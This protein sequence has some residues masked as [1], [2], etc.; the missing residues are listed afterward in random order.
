MKKKETFTKHNGIIAIW[1]FLFALL[2]LCFHC[3]ILIDPNP[4]R[5]L[6]VKGSIGVEFFFLVSGY[7]LARKVFE[8]EA[9]DTR[10]IYQSTW[11]YLCHK[12]K[13]FYPYLLFAFVIIT[14]SDVFLHHNLSPIIH[15]EKMAELTL[16]NQ[17]GLSFPFFSNVSWYLSALVIASA[18]I[19]PLLKKYQKTFSSLVAPILG[20][21]ICCF[22]IHY[23]NGH[24]R[25]PGNYICFAYEGF[26]R[27]FAE[28]LLGITAYEL[29]L[30]LKKVN[31]TKIGS[32]ALSV[33]CF[34]S[35]AFVFLFNA[36]YK[37]A[38]KVDYISLILLLIGV[39]VAFSGK[40]FFFEKCN[41]KIFYYLERLSLPLYLNNCIFIYIIDSELIKGAFTL[42]YPLKFVLVILLTILF[43]ALE[44]YLMKYIMRLYDKIKN[45][46]KKIIIEG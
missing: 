25:G 41:N 46:C 2:I 12:I 45:R 28:L 11:Q 23:N 40:T 31:F 35:L 8:D 37:R 3:A 9:K 19:Y 4:S 24:L 5:S 7:L 32:I 38:I 21:L 20:I 13:S 33:V 42:S 16:L 36:L 26:F 39:V 27:G 15:L 22:L 44:L 30:R 10:P 29:V 17:A 43:S 34:S 1:K 6:F 18:I 14:A